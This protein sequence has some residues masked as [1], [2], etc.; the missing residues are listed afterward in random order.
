M[1]NY[2][3]IRTADELRKAIETLSNQPVVG[4]DTEPPNSIRIPLDCA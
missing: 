4:L 3:L 1:T 2:E